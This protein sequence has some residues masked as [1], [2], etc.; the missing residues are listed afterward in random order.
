M[1][2]GRATLPP[3]P[4]PMRDD[5]L[6]VCPPLLPAWPVSPGGELHLTRRAEFGEYAA[7]SID[8]IRRRRSGRIPRRS[9][10]RRVCLASNCWSTGLVRPFQGCGISCA[11]E[12]LIWALYMTLGLDAP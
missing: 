4:R 11:P 10:N 1:P 3:D 7:K 9:L 6:S 8:Q 5:Q 12:W 2:P